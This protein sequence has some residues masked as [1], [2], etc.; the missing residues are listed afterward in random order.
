[1]CNPSSSGS[2]R[3]C[4][5]DPSRVPCQTRDAAR[6]SRSAKH[7]TPRAARIRAAGVARDPSTRIAG[8]ARRRGWRTCRRRCAPPSR[9]SS[10][11]AGGVRLGGEKCREV[12]HL[13]ILFLLYLFTELTFSGEKPGSTHTNPSRSP[14][15]SILVH[16]HA[17]HLRKKERLACPAPCMKERRRPAPSHILLL[18]VGVPA[19]TGHR[20]QE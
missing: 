1:M 17:Q 6:V 2:S 19:R 5:W 16:S 20:M 18:V 8:R 11:G 3:G 4:G 15:P 12:L 13:C 14:P 9:R 10:A 7:C